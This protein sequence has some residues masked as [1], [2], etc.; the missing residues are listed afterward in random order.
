[1]HRLLSL[2]TYMI[3]ALIAVAV[4]GH[5]NHSSAQEMRFF[6]LGTGPTA[7][8]RFPIGGMIAS[9]LSNPPGSRGCDRG[10]SCGV[11]GLLAVAKSTDGSIANVDAIRTRRLD[12]ALVHADV[13][14][15]AHH[16]I[17]PYKGKPVENLR[18]IAQI[19]SESL[20]LVVRADAKIA[21]VQ[22]LKG[23]RVS[24]GEKD[25]STALLSRALLAAY[26]LSLSQV[27]ESWLKPGAAAEALADD[28]LDA[29]LALDGQ[30]LTGL[31]D[32]ASRV[33]IGLI[34]I[35]GAGAERLRA[36]NPYLTPGVISPLPKTG[37]A[38]VP[39]LEIGVIL[40]TPEEEDAALV[41]GIT[42]ALWHP[43]TRKLLAQGN[44]LGRLIR[45]DV[46]ALDTMGI[47]LH[48]GAR[49]YYADAAAEAQGAAIP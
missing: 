17:G 46:K 38:P 11:P 2:P 34:P 41:K 33:A 13:A 49:A 37:G 18:G 25:S 9:A 47:P 48:L 24:F 12:A 3:A 14:F 15:W 45:L 22:D 29:F 35:D 21:D 42:R 26:G 36:A 1:M 27:K 16:G 4:L 43:S 23:K 39:T 30:P 28:K 7:E 44:P 20:Y 5:G 32:L 10:G 19:Y 40:V 8:A 31:S 6:Q